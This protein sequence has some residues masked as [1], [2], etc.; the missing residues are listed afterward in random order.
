MIGTSIVFEPVWEELKKYLHLVEHGDQV[1]IDFLDVPELR[2]REL[3]MYEMPCIACLRPNHPIRRREGDFFDRLY[4]APTCE[5]TRRMGCSRSRAAALEYQRF[6]GLKLDEKP[7]A[8]L[9]LF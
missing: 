9:A 5:L 8:Q 1:R 4:Y 6:L 3:V 7:L 2:A